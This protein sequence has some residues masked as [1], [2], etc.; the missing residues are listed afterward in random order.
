MPLTQSSSRAAIGPNIRREEAAGKPYRQALAIALSTQDRNRRATGGGILARMNGRGILHRDMGGATD[1]TIGGVAP[2]GGTMNPM[3][4]SLVQRYSA[5]SPQQLQQLAGML[6]SSPQGQLVQRILS[7]KRMMPNL[8]QPAAPVAPSP[9]AP[10]MADGGNVHDP[11]EYINRL[12]VE[13]RPGDGWY[14]GTAYQPGGAMSGYGYGPFSDL[15]DLQDSV[16]ALNAFRHK[17][18]GGPLHRQMG[19]M[20]SMSPWWERSEARDMGNEGSG[21]LHSAVA[22]RTDHIALNAPDGAYVIPADVVSGLGEGNTLAGARVLSEALNTGPFGTALPR[23]ARGPGPPAAPHSTRM[24][25]LESRGGRAHG[26]VPVMAAGGEYIISPRQVM[27]IGEGDLKRGHE[28]LD[29]W[30]VERR[31]KNVK[32]TTKLPGPAK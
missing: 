31:K 4:Q 26:T 21:L 2:T 9:G 15:E 12:V 8:G 27:M 19:G 32:E 20:S 10:A 14:W 11:F 18:H 5:M 30:V 13:N 22:G 29:K 25:M 23:G 6:G 28:R 1:P 17:A 7:Q 3:A 16:T 24:P